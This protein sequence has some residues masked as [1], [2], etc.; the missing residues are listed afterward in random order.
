MLSRYCCIVIF[1]LVQLKPCRKVVGY[2]SSDPCFVVL[3]FKLS[4]FDAG[5][6]QAVGGIWTV[7]LC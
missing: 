3:I 5:M 2:C 4:E 6:S 7:N 1:I